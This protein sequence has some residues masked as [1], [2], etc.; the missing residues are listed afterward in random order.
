MYRPFEFG[1]FIALVGIVAA[2]AVPVLYYFAV[3]FGWP[4]WIVLPAA[5][6]GAVVLAF[7]SLFALAA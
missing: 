6:L 2:I 1:V 4:D 3:Q 7:T 5:I